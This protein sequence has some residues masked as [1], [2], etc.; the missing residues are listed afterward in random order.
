VA[1]RTGDIEASPLERC[2]DP[3]PDGEPIHVEPLEPKPDADELERFK[4]TTARINRC[5]KRTSGPAFAT[6]QSWPH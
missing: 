2:A 4:R 6:R 5:A 1:G 3:L